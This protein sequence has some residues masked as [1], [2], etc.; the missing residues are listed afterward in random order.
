MFDW[1]YIQKIAKMEQRMIS[2]EDVCTC[3]CGS[4]QVGTCKGCK[5][6]QA[7]H[8]I[9]SLIEKKYKEIINEFGELKF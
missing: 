5:C 4:W 1:N 7:T 6:S 9:N 3:G 2:N 8:E